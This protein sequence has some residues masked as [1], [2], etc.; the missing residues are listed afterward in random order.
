VLEGKSDQETA[1][2]TIDNYRPA[3]TGTPTVHC[4]DDITA[5]DYERLGLVRNG[6]IEA[7]SPVDAA[8]VLGAQ[9]FSPPRPPG[10]Y[11]PAGSTPPPAPYMRVLRDRRTGFVYAELLTADLST[12][13]S[14]LECP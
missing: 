5:D 3:I 8:V 13:L 11:R 10:Y 12:A 4:V 6:I 14:G 2:Y 9:N 1:D 7:E